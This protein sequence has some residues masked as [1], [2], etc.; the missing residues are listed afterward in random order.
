MVILRFD[1]TKADHAIR[2]CFD[3]VLEM[4]GASDE[5]F[6]VSLDVYGLLFL[7]APHVIKTVWKLLTKAI[8]TTD[9][10]VWSFFGS[11]LGRT[12]CGSRTSRQFR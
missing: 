12:L 6:C 4:Y 8:Y 3:I 5:G 9:F 7:E 11:L 1:D 10:L 2:F